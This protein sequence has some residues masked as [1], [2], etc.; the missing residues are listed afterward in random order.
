MF[1][2]SGIMLG[3]Q[4]THLYHLFALLVPP[5]AWWLTLPV[6]RKE[7][8]TILHNSSLAVAYWEET[9]FRGVILGGTLSAWH[10]FPL[11][12]VASSLLFGVFHLRNSWS[13]S[14]KQVIINCL[15]TGLI[16]G[17]IIALLRYWSGGHR[18]SRGSQLRADGATDKSTKAN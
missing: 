10:S 14:P 8:L 15:Y 18:I 16:F 2:Y 9:L 4:P 12:L 7:H 1:C 3:F 11:A 6:A 5:L 17:P 13:S